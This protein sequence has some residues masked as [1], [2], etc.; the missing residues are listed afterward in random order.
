LR[1]GFDISRSAVLLSPCGMDEL[2]DGLL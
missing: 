1:D 2:S